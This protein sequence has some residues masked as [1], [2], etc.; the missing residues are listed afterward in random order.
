MGQQ[1]ISQGLPSMTPVDR[2]GVPLAKVPQFIEF[3][4]PA[5]VA[6]GATGQVIYTVGVRNFICTHLGFTSA[7]VG[8]PL[9]DQ[10]FKIS[11]RDIGSNTSFE[12]HRWNTT[13][14]LG[15]NQGIGDVKPF[16]LSVEWEFQAKTSIRVEFEN[17]GTLPCMPN[18][19]MIG[20]LDAMQ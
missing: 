8:V 15:R 12:P 20:Y 9:A 2:K 16:R 3:E 18:L 19:C 14:A 1:G 11:I 6:A 17:I 13:S 4:P 5:A 7:P 10:R